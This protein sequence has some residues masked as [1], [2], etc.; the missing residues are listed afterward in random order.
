MQFG[1]DNFPKYSG[2]SG[3]IVGVKAGIAA[4]LTNAGG[5]I[6]AVYGYDADNQYLGSGNGGGIDEGGL[7]TTTIDQSVP[8]IQTDFVDVTFT[9]DAV[10]V[11]WITVEMHDGSP[12]GAWTGDIG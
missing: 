11:A 8:D 5:G 3:A 6:N 4:D 7:F 2:P 9:D 12:S 10:C 1:F